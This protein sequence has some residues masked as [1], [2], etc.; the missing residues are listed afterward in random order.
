MTREVLTAQ[1]QAEGQEAGPRVELGHQRHPQV[2]EVV[3]V[4]SPLACCSRQ[5]CL[6]A[7]LVVVDL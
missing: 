7:V 4:L 1:A 3:P 6:L 2:L 5:G